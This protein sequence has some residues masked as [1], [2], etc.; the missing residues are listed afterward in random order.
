[1]VWSQVHKENNRSACSPP[2]PLAPSLL[3]H[4]AHTILP[5]SCVTSMGNLSI[6]QTYT[7]NNDNS[8]YDLLHLAPDLSLPC[9]P[10]PLSTPQTNH[11]ARSPSNFPH[12]SAHQTPFH[13]HLTLSVTP[14][15]PSRTST[16]NC[17]RASPMGS[18]RPSQIERRVLACRPSDMKTESTTSNNVY[19]I[20]RRTSMSLR[21]ATNSTTGRSLTSRS[22]SEV[23]YTKRP[24]GSVSMTT[25]TFPA[26]TA[27]RGPTNSPTSST[28]TPPPIIVSTCPSNPSRHGSDIC[29]PAQAAT[30]KFYKMA[31]PIQGTG[32][33][34]R[35]LPSTASSMMTSPQSPLRLKN[36][37]MT[38]M[39]LGHDWDHVSLASC[40]PGPRKW[41]PHCRMYRGRLEHYVPGGRRLLACHGA[42]TSVLHRWRTNRDV[43]GCP[44]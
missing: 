37:S 8:P 13:S 12:T 26:I 43:R 25:V 1:L 40:F 9:P 32:D 38:W 27:P 29:S 2:A 19:S 4:R 5:S 42:F 14:S 28:S 11:H 15:K 6:S 20:T 39:P 22:Q 21:Q 36:T 31:W 33:W 16:M 23:V 10:S 30:F 24:S 44:S 3:A 35:R 17:Y 7:I 18:S 41:W 34:L